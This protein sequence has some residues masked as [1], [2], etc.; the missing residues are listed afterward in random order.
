MRGYGQF[1][2]IARGSEILAAR[3]TPIILRNVLLGCHTFNEI[4]A[5]AP[6]LSRA[7]LAR[8]L[9]ELE[10]AGVIRI[11]PKPD[12][13][14][15]LYEP[16]P[17]G[18]DLEP[19]LLALGRWAERSVGLTADHADPD[20]VLWSWCQEFLRRDLLPGRRIV[21]RFDFSFL[22]RRRKVWMLVDGREVELCRFDPGF[23]DD[24][25]VTI[26]DPLTFARWHLG[27]VEWAAALRSGAVHVSGPRALSR[28][29]PTWNA[30][31][32]TWARRRVALEQ[33][34]GAGPASP[35]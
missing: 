23:G 12:G 35:R 29:L 32:E 15:S 11:R 20:V 26:H 16:T 31:P 4:A 7:L 34:S 33:T 5:G 2:P 17:L 28:A 8:R 25:V 14:G 10:H 9:H 27:L 19:V 3:W 22:D 18:R 1:C 13:R 21:V 24:L 6:G 30:G